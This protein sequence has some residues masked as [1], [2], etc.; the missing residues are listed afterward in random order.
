MK[1]YKG[2]KVKFRRLTNSCFAVACS[3][4]SP[5]LGAVEVQGLHI[6]PLRGLQEL[7]AAPLKELHTLPL[8]GPGDVERSSKEVVA[9]CTAALRGLYK[10]D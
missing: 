2:Q 4:M 7:Y 6:T 1:C 9:L 10:Q 8:R 5:V 3:Q